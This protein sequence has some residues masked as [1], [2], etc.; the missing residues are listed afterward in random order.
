MQMARRVLGISAAALFL[1]ATTRPGWADGLSRFDRTIKPKIPPGALTYKSAKGLGDS[2]FLLEDVVITPPPD[3]TPGSKAEPIN[4]K[5]IAVEDFDF[6]SIEKETPPNFVKVKVEGIA[7]AGKPA[8]GVDLK[9]LAGIDSISADL[10]LDYRLEPERQIMTLNRLELGVN[11]IARLELSLIMDGV[12]ADMATNPDAAFDK[13]TVRTATLIYDDQSLLAK[14]LP[15]LAGIQG[16]DPAAMIT[17]AKATLGAA[18]SGQGPEAQAA[19]DAVG[20]Y[21]EDYQKP[22]GPLKLTM[23]PAD[24]LSAAALSN[25]KSPDEVVKALGLVVSY[26]GMRP[27]AASSSTAGGTAP[28]CNAGTRFFVYHDDV[29]WPATARDSSKSGKE[30]IARIEGAGEDIVVPVDKTVAWSID[31]PGKALD[32]CVGGAKVVVRDKDDGGW[33]PGKVADKPS[34]AGQCSIKYDDAN[35]DD[36]TVPLKRVRRLD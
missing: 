31:G 11:G 36:E 6:A 3:K 24:K 2:G 28:A 34:A 30:C 12:S 10:V 33:Y 13:A 7:I 8:E 23:N 32:K 22:K 29:W 15:I 35:N 14:A 19:L 16:T 9:E 18:R 4:V 5:R 25:A 21:I 20:S 17:L 26:A 1:L 27:G